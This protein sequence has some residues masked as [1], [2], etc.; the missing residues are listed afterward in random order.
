MIP[1]MNVIKD[2]DPRL[3]SAA[4]WSIL[5]ELVLSAALLGGCYVNFTRTFL[6]GAKFKD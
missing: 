5:F 4:L 6:F 2:P 1:L 3:M